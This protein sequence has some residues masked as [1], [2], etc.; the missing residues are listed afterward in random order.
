MSDVKLVSRE[1]VTAEMKASPL[2][3]KPVAGKP[4]MGYLGDLGHV[5]ASKEQ[6]TKEALF[7]MSEPEPLVQSAAQKER[8]REYERQLATDRA[9]S[10]SLAT[11]GGLA[12]RI[13]GLLSSNDDGPKKR[14]IFK[15]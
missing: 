10:S 3:E 6:L 4:V 14:S 2:Y 13:V 8:A 11:F 9:I 7:G 12:K 1:E 5:Y 15:P